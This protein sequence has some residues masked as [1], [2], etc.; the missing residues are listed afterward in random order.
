MLGPRM[1]APLDLEESYFAS[2]EHN[3][4][5]S[6]LTSETESTMLQLDVSPPAH[7]AAWEVD[8]TIDPALLSQREDLES[9]INQVA[10]MQHS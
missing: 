9:S 6:W 8:A 10:P 3:D 5:I 4:T 1:R 2:T 7:A